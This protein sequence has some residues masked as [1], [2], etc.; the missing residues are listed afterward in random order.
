MDMVEQIRGGDIRTSARLIRDIDDGV[1]EARTVLK[2]L[3]PYTGRAHIIG[4]TG[5][6]GV[7][8]STLTDKMIQY[9]REHDKTVGVVAVDPTSPFSGGAILGDRIRMQ[10]HAT[11]EGVFI[12]SLATRGHFGGLTV[13]ARAVIAVLDAMGKDYILVETV[14]VGQDEVE[15]VSTAHT[16]LVVT[17]PGMGD[18]IQAIKAGILEVGDL[19]VINKAD[20]D[21]AERTYQELVTML[22]MR[23]ATREADSWQPGVYLTEAPRNVGISELMQGIFAHQEFLQQD[24]GKL[25]QKT[26]YQRTRAELLDLIKAGIAQKI[27]QSLTAYD[28]LEQLIADILDKKTDPY[29]VSEEIV[30]RTLKQCKF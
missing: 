8:K 16:T 5:A 30:A 18:D 15:V 13:S 28:R 6:P 21:G 11:D 27:M 24:G 4:I 2:A 22:E 1:P 25:L 14:G 12:R 17:V 23:A 7:G 20:R 10:R 3:H 19:F 26:L 9:L 29:T